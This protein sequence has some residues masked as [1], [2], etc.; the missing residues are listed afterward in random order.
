[1]NDVKH[2]QKLRGTKDKFSFLLNF[3]H[4]PKLVLYELSIPRPFKIFVIRNQWE[5]E[6][7]LCNKENQLAWT[8]EVTKN[9]L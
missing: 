2:K 3:I 4:P 8:K 5:N 6:T 7:E 9:I 1:M